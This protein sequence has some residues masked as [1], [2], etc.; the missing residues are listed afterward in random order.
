MSNILFLL[1]KVIGNLMM[2]LSFS[3]MLLVVGLL[4][5]WFS[6]AS[7]KKNSFAKILL[8]VATCILF[9]A[10]SPLSSLQ[11]TQVLERQHPALFEPPKNLQYVM[12]L[13]NGHL[14]DPALPAIAQLSPASYYRV[15]EGIRLMHANPQATLLVSGFGGSDPISN[16]QLASTVAQQY[17]IKKQNIRLFP[18]AKDT[19]E[20]A[21]LMSQVIQQRHSALVTSATHMPRALKLFQQQGSNP[22]PAPV[23]FLGKQPQQDKFFYEYLPKAGDLNKVTVAWHELVGQFWQKIK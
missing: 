2:P 15:M 4:L 9:I 21:V 6:E 3:L 16:A 22:L 8:T 19:E 5:L 20:E 18:Q 11:L 17:G 1:K 13:G 12:V 14:S 10:S 7:S 23:Y